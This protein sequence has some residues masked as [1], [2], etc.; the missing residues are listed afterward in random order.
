M[1]NDSFLSLWLRNLLFVAPL[2]NIK[3]QIS[4]VKAEII[5]MDVRIGILECI[6]LQTKIRD[7]KNLESEFGQ[8]ISVF[9]TIKNNFIYFSCTWIKEENNQ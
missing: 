7:E 9:W 1:F 5:D 8:T 4:K 3:K 6:L 2:V